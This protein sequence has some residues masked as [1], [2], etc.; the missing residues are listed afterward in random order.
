MT[1]PSCKTKS[2][3][4]CRQIIKDYSHYCRTPH[5]NHESCNKCVLHTNAK[6]DDRLARREVAQKALL[7]AQKREGAPAAAII[8]GLLSPSPNKHLMEGARDP[9][10][11]VRQALNGARPNVDQ[12]PPNEPV[13][14]QNVIVQQH[15]QQQ[16]DQDQPQ[17]GQEAPRAA[18]GD[19]AAAHPRLH[20]V[21]E[22]DMQPNGNDGRDRR[23]QRDHVMEPNV[24]GTNEGI[25]L[26]AHDLIVL[27]NSTR[28]PRDA[29]ELQVQQLQHQ[30]NDPVHQPQEE[31][32][33][34][35]S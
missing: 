21:D 24:V 6:E 20:I 7:A 16:H 11:P 10:Q 30:G 34:I 13:Q 19:E 26:T 35:I 22:L 28:G 1:C 29:L 25:T 33:C 8:G 2:C 9:L 27:Q 31:D 5:C 12:P 23:G 17:R 18:Q 32:G 14:R 3:Y 4:F 15:Q